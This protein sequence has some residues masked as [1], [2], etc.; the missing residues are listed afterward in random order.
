MRQP[1]RI[2]HRPSSHLSSASEPHMSQRASPIL[3]TSPKPFTGTA[4]HWADMSCFPGR[5][6]PRG[7]RHGQTGRRLG[8][9]GRRWAAAPARARQSQVLTRR[10]SRAAHRRPRRHR[11]APTHLR[12]TR[13]GRP[14][15]RH[16]CSPSSG[17]RSS[18]QP[19]KPLL[20]ISGLH[21]LIFIDCLVCVCERGS[22]LSLA[23]FA[24]D[25]KHRD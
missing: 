19:E 1:C 20:L 14:H 11:I 5:R 23:E 22:A 10:H 8:R 18:T 21:E 17:H 9:V 2:T 4:L 7:T 24:Q 6:P 15:H 25:S 3:R 16:S 13:C 12:W